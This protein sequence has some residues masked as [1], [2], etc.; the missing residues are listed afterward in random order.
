MAET[1]K[2]FMIKSDD[3]GD[4]KVSEEVVAIIAGLAATEVDGVNSMAGNITNEII[5]KLGLKNLSKGIGVEVLDGEIK[6]DVALNIEFGVA[7]PE[8]SEKVQE[9]VKTA[10]E[11]MTGLTVA[12]VNVRIVSVDAEEN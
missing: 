6:I 4:V 2:T 1:N 5:S 8:I 10:V 7:I 9:R 11:N 3:L 12:V